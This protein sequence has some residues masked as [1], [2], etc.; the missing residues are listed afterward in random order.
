M[1]NR[2]HESAPWYSRLSPGRSF[3]GSERHPKVRG[4]CQSFY[5][6]LSYLLCTSNISP[7][8]HLSTTS[9]DRRRSPR[10][11]PAPRRRL[12]PPRISA[13]TATPPQARARPPA[14]APAG[15]R[16]AAWHRKLIVTCSLL[17]GIPTAWNSAIMM[18]AISKKAEC[19]HYVKCANQI[20]SDIG[21]E[22]RQR[23]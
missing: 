1:S 7:G 9:K 23:S 17:A 21:C 13:A 2:A 5:P 18:N 3:A 15:G 22:R 16:G 8:R 20:C 4:F 14:R 12:P 10:R 19:A 11:G 6:D